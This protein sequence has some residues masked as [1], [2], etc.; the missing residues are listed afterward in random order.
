MQEIPAMNGS[1][2]FQ[3]TTHPSMI[4]DSLRIIP[5]RVEMRA[6]FKLEIKG[7]DPKGKYFAQKVQ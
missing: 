4:T 2:F 6:C 3:V 5:S 7:C 1:H